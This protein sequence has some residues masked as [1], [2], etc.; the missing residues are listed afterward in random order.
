MKKIE[1]YGD[2]FDIYDEGKLKNGIS[3]SMVASDTKT[4]VV[5][6]NPNFLKEDLRNELEKDQWHLPPHSFGITFN[7]MNNH[8]VF[9]TSIIDRTRVKEI[10]V[11][12][13]L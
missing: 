8:M 5:F 9:S 6:H 12:I 1:L 2:S 7:K 10:I 13:N 4:Y 3:W 11:D